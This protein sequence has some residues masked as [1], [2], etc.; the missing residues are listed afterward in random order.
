MFGNTCLGEL[1]YEA[2]ATSITMAGA[3]LAFLVDFTAHRLAYWRR[4]KA[5]TFNAGEDANPDSSAPDSKGQGATTP[6]AVSSHHANH[7][8]ATTMPFLYLY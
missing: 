4:S 2:T 8:P 1:Q 3:F 7:D 5:S 6:L